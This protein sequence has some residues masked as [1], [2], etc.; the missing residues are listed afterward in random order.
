MSIHEERFFGENLGGDEDQAQ[1]RR[2]MVR[3][4]DPPFQRLL[5]MS[6][7]VR[8][9][10]IALGASANEAVGARVLP[11]LLPEDARP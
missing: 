8:S 9:P 2:G 7:L 1:M 11:L 3:G 5:P 6:D 4:G 10:E